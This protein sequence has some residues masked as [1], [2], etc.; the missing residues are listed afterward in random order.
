MK[1]WSL[2][3]LIP[4]VASGGEVKLQPYFP[5]PYPQQPFSLAGQ[6]FLDDLDSVNGVWTGTCL[7][8]GG[9][10]RSQESPAIVTWATTGTPLS[11]TPC[12]L[13]AYEGS[14]VCPPKTYGKFGKYGGFYG[15]LQGVD[16]GGYLGIMIDGTGVNVPALTT[17]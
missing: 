12:Y 11:A 16:P 15:W 6:C 14:P 3:A 10:P 8:Y 1:A 5:S 13:H 17:P 2:L 7:Y 4:V 9:N